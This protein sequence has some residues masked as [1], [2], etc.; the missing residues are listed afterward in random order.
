MSG[1]IEVSKDPG[2]TK[3]LA[4]VRVEYSTPSPSSPE[5][6]S[7]PTGLSCPPTMIQAALFLGCILLSSVTA[8]PWKTQDGGLPH[9][10][11]G[12]ETEPTSTVLYSKI[13]PLTSSTCRNLLNMV[14]LPPVAPLSE[15]LSLLAL[16]IVL[17]NIG[18]PA[19]AYSLQLRLREM[20]GKDRTE[21]LILE[22]QKHSQEEGIGN[23]EAILRHLVASPGEIK[24]VERSVTVPEACTSEQGLVLREFAQLL[25]ELAEK[26]PSID[27]VRE[28]KASAVNATQQCTMESWEH[29]NEVG[30]RLI[31]NPEIEN[32]TIP[33]EDRIYFISRLTVLLKRA[34]VSFLRKVFQTYFG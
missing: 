16:R 23:N 29:M 26:L 1:E 21:T 15:S 2:S 24:R 34:F 10:P 25:V 27:L 30:K 20:G 32:A 8:F 17:E 33:I 9:H 13:P 11:A 12:T 7:F 4:A 5:L 22:S 6:C 14:S 18:C 19:E 28:F 31:S 3:L